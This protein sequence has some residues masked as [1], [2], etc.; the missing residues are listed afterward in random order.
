MAFKLIQRGSFRELDKEFTSLIGRDG[1]IDLD[2]MGSAE[3]EWGGN[4]R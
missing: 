2:Y 1:L 3:F 4:K